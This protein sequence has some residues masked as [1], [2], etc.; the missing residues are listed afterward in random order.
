MPVPFER[1]K[2]ELEVEHK[3]LHDQLSN[4]AAT[5]VGEAVG[6]GLHQAD[7]ATEAFEQ[8][9]RLT[10]RRNS[11]DLLRRVEAALAR[12]EDGTYGLCMRCGRPIDPA[13]L[14]AIQYAELCMDCQGQF[15]RK[16]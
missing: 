1:L 6:Y 16:R 10:I 7:H 11:E 9:K 8:T 13:R 15:E 2:G 12:F 5:D 4:P 14:E 3:R